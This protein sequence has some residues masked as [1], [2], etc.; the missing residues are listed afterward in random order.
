MLEKLRE[1]KR[2]IHVA[3]A[4]IERDSLVLAVQRS[5]AMSMPLK[6]EFPGGKI[7]S[8][9]SPEDCVR[10]ELLEELGLQISIDGQL[11]PS[12]HRYPTFTITLYPFTCSI[13]SGEMVLHEHSGALWLRPEKL[14]TLD[15][16][17]ADTSAINNYCISL[18]RKV[19]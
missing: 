11:P 5:P 12:T 19:T 18:N 1:F 8:H 17:E 7:E 15:W 9:E 16:A 10:R 13:Q 14:L 6:W 2:H 3:C 4:I